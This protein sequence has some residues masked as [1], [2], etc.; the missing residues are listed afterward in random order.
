MDAL[1]RKRG[2]GPK[3]PEERRRRTK[4]LEEAK[5]PVVV[6][7]VDTRST[8]GSFEWRV[9]GERYVSPSEARH[10]AA[11]AVRSAYPSGRSLEEVVLVGRGIRPSG[12]LP[13]RTIL[14]EGNELERLREERVALE[15]IRG[16]L[17]KHEKRL[18]VVV[19]RLDRAEE[20]IGKALGG[21]ERLEDVTRSFSTLVAQMEDLLTYFERRRHP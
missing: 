8:V 5:P 6:K 4:N 13:V 9:K 7:P 18:V 21:L 14:K 15:D 3:P 19:T 11:R 1:A 20:R 12:P 2:K 16:K 17:E 10:P